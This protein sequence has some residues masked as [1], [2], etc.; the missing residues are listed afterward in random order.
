MRAHLSGECIP[1]RQ[2]MPNANVALCTLIERCMSLEPK[3]RP[4]ARELATE[5]A[6]IQGQLSMMPAAAVSQGNAVP[7]LFLR[8]K[9]VQATPFFARTTTWIVFAATLVWRAW[10]TST[11]Q[12]A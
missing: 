9:K 12:E 8:Q 4:T 11:K 5:L 1:L 10:L 6:R 7:N 2:L 3:K